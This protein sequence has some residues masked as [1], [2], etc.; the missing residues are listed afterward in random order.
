MEIVID[1]LPLSKRNRLA[2]GAIFRVK[3]GSGPY[4]VGSQTPVGVHPG[5]YRCL[6]LFSYSQRPSRIYCDAVD[7]KSG[8]T[9]TL[10][11]QGPAF[12]SKANDSI[13]C[14]P[15]DVALVKDSKITRRESRARKD[16]DRSHRLQ[17]A[18]RR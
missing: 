15:Y 8:R 3:R 11:L 4:L 14:R 5:E 18:S 9:H 1:A 12:R 10:Y 7:Q 13:Q 16:R 17:R 2:A 6:R